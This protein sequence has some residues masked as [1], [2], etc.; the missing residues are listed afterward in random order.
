M[1]APSSVAPGS[2]VSTA[3]N[4]S[5]S[6][7]ACVDFPEASPPSNAISTSD[8]RSL[9][10][11]RTQRPDHDRAGDDDDEPGEPQGEPFTGDEEVTTEQRDRA[12]VEDLPRDVV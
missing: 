4:R 7:R 3:P 6:S 8:A 12:V 9:R 10:F 1:R 11:A 5:A 2:C